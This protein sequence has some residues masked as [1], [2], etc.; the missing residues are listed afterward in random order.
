MN[1]SRQKQW[2]WS[3]MNNDHSVK[4]TFPNRYITWQASTCII[5]CVVGADKL[6]SLLT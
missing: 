5:V 2:S 6:S 1:N 4:L 3:F